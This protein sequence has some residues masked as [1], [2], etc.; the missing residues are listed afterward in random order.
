VSE[1]RAAPEVESQSG[2]ETSCDGF[3][4]IPCR[5]VLAPAIPF[6][7]AQRR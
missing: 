7:G 3:T 6:G 1:R 4:D 5:I 2:E